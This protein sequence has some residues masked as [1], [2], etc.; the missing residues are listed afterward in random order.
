MR[1][2]ELAHSLTCHLPDL[3]QK[4]M[5]GCLETGRHKELCVRASEAS[6]LWIVEIL[7]GFHLWRGDYA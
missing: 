6:D 3:L 7:M 2:L 1:W 4:M 5:I